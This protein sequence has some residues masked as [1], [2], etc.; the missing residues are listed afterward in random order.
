[1]RPFGHTEVREER[2]DRIVP[3]DDRLTEAWETFISRSDER[4]FASMGNFVLPEEDFSFAQHATRDV[5]VTVNQVHRF[6]LSGKMGDA[7]GRAVGLFLSACYANAPDTEIVYD[8]YTPGMVCLGYRLSGKHLINNGVVG[9]HLGEKMMG[10]LTNNGVAGDLSGFRMIGTYNNA[11]HVRST[12]GID[13]IGAIT[14]RRY[15]VRLYRRH[16]RFT[17]KCN[18]RWYNVSPHRREEFLRMAENPSDLSYNAL[19]DKLSRKYGG[20]R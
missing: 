20:K 6:F 8:F 17:G 9:E 18:K 1:M 11:G 3:L 13:M 14:T 12:P 5:D 15:P 16:D 10:R 7:S 2:D 4:H 19:Y